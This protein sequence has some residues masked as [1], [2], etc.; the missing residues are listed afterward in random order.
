VRGILWG[1]CETFCGGWRGVVP[2]DSR[3]TIAG[4]PCR[5]FSS[6][7]R[8]RGQPPSRRGRD[9]A[10]LRPS[11]RPP[12]VVA[13]RFELVEGGVSQH[14]CHIMFAAFAQIIGDATPF[15]GLLS[16]RQ[17][18]TF[19]VAT[20]LAGANPHRFITANPGVSAAGAAAPRVTRDEAVARASD[21]SPP[22][23]KPDDVRFLDLLFPSL[24]GSPV[25]NEPRNLAGI[26]S[27]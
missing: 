8:R 14:R 1:L 5:L 23:I 17:T 24:R 21:A 11:R 4:N 18:R 16:L 20:V 2:P 3:F 9:E 25:Q 6:V 15:L 12:A 10:F 27:P 13:G 22:S 26:A 19:F 7:A